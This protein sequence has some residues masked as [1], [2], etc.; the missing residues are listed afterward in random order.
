M[1]SLSQ[2]E[3]KSIYLFDKKIR[4]SIKED[5]PIVCADDVF[6]A[7]FGSDKY[8]HV[9]KIAERF[10]S[11]GYFKSKSKTFEL[12]TLHQINNRFIDYDVP[13]SKFKRNPDKYQNY[14][15]FIQK[16]ACNYIL[17]L[18]IK[19][20]EDELS[21]D[22]FN[23]KKIDNLL[24]LDLEPEQ[25]SEENSM[26][27]YKNIEHLQSE[28]EQLKKEVKHLEIHSD[29]K[30]KALEERSERIKEL[31][32][33]IAAQSQK[34][35]ELE[36]KIEQ[37]SKDSAELKK[38]QDAKNKNKLRAFMTNDKTRIAASI[39]ATAAFLPFTFLALLEYISIPMPNIF[40]AI[41][42][43]LLC[44]IIAAI[45]DF[46]IIYFSENGKDALAITGAI[47]QFI[48]LGAKFD[49]FAS[50][51]NNFNPVWNGDH[52]QFMIVMTAICIYSPILVINFAFLAKKK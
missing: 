33:E 43:G 34:T 7:L 1:K 2:S 35:Q 39:S 19:D 22:Y 10:E 36:Q 29:A 3:I 26:N 42:V 28:V 41:L 11:Y 6:N 16:G 23:V 52:I 25:K 27:T 17:E 44:L 8:S 5:Y 40:I 18:I 30:Q 47:F 50:W 12:Y 24:N 14:V 46:A 51:I 15:E 9:K 38:L 49:F 45:W 37:L 21:D 20:S 32:E 31:N 13:E 48:F 4:F